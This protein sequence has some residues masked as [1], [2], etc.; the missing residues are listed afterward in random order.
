MFEKET[1]EYAEKKIC[2]EYNDDCMGFDKCKEYCERYHNT[3]KYWKDGAEFGYNKANEEMKDIIKKL[4]HKLIM[5]S[6]PYKTDLT[7][8]EIA[9]I[10]K[11]IP[12]ED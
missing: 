1:E 7:E 4:L 8:E 2:Q 3:Q 6:A 11:F 12:K 9:E 10:R 5:T